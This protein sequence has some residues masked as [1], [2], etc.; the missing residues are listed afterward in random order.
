[1]FKELGASSN[2]CSNN[3]ILGLKVNGKSVSDESVL[4]EHFNEYFINVAFKLK[5]PNEQ[6][7]FS[8]LKSFMIKKFTKM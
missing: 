1:M 2:K 8:K 5:E 7:G 6:T 4:A 3:D